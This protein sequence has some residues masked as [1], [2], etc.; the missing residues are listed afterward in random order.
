VGAIFQRLFDPATGCTR[1]QFKNYLF[2]TINFT[3]NTKYQL[4]RTFYISATSQRQV[5][6]ALLGN[7]TARNRDC[8]TSGR[9]VTRSV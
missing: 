7:L 5:I 2:Q 1:K 3:E 4:G 6:L 8:P 9:G